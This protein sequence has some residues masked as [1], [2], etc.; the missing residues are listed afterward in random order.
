M[1]ITTKI[2]NDRL[3]RVGP[4][5]PMGDM[6]REYWVPA[7]RSASVEA[8]GAP[9]R[10]RLFGENFVVFRA[11]DGRVGFLQE[12]CPHRC[13]SLALARNA[14]LRSRRQQRQHRGSGTHVGIAAQLAVHGLELAAHRFGLLRLRQQTFQRRTEILDRGIGLNVFGHQ[15]A[16]GEVV[17]QR[18][19][20]YLQHRTRHQE[21]QP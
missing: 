8:D 15:L 3:T 7:C 5:T 4:G 9:F 20:L 14:F 17:W 13:A 16:P 2:D 21:V 10:A 6:L 1:A 11:T 19:Q 12:G 18:H